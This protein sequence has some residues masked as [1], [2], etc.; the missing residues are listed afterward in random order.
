VRKFLLVYS[1][2]LMCILCIFFSEVILVLKIM[3]HNFIVE[4][5]EG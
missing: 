4:S 3:L 2:L 1:K 5:G